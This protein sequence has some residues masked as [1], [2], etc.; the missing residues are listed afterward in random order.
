MQDHVDFG[1]Q[2]MGEAMHQLAQPSSQVL[3]LSL[4]AKMKT[5]EWA[6]VT[7]CSVQGT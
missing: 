4:L 1:V 5:R 6:T 2:G 7:C 3:T